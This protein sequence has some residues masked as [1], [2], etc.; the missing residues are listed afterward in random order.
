MLLAQCSFL[1]RNLAHREVCLVVHTLVST[2][3]LT[4]LA[5]AARS[6]PELTK[7][8]IITNYLLAIYLTLYLVLVSSL[9]LQSNRFA[10]IQHQYPIALKI[11]PGCKSLQK[12]SIIW[13]SGIRRFTAC[14]KYRA[15]HFHVPRSQRFLFRGS[16][17]SVPKLSIFSKSSWP[18]VLRYVN[19]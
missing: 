9:D 7:S 14:P 10:L 3:P 17:A 5:P 16:L 12:S 6:A 19:P 1:S 18:A 11:P 2:N 15:S 4:K 13:I 8:I